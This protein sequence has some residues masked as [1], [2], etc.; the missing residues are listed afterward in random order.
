MGINWRENHRWNH[1]GNYGGN[2]KELFV[3]YCS[4]D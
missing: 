4:S 2:H 3:N 1:C